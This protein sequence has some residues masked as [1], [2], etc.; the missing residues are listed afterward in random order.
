MLRGRLGSVARGAP[1]VRG[2]R[3]IQE[4]TGPL[5]EARD[6]ETKF[7]DPRKPAVLD[8]GGRLRRLVARDPMVLPEEEVERAFENSI[9]IH[10]G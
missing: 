9:E 2:R 3:P 5:V 8:I 7:V 10:R 6:D 4:S 1:H